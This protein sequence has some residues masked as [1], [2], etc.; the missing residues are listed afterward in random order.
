MTIGYVVVYR[1][2]EDPQWRWTNTL[3]EDPPTREQA[4]ADAPD[5]SAWRIHEVTLDASPQ[6]EWAST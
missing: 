5:A 4:E 3:H 2:A 6:D 1:T